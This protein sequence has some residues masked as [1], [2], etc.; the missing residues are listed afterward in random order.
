MNA[1]DSDGIPGLGGC[2]PMI[3]MAILFI[4]FGFTMGYWI[5]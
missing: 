1:G 3:A 5:A 4:G 2:S